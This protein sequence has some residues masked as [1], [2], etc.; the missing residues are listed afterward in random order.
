MSNIYKSLIAAFDHHYTKDELVKGIYSL[1][2]LFFKENEGFHEKYG[3]PDYVDSDP[4]VKG[5]PSKM[6]VLE[7]CATVFVNEPIFKAFS[8]FLPENTRRVLEVLVWEYKMEIPLLEKELKIFIREVRKDNFF[9]RFSNTIFEDFYFFKGALD[10][11]SGEFSIPDKLAQ[12]LRAFYEKPKGYQLEAVTQ[13]APTDMVYESGA[14][15]I[16]EEMMRLTHYYS[17]DKISRN[18]AGNILYSTANKTRKALRLREFFDEDYKEGASV[19]THFLIQL[20]GTQG[21]VSP[22][23]SPTELIKTLFDNYKKGMV[24]NVAQVFVLHLK[25]TGH[26]HTY[27]PSKIAVTFLSLL[28]ELSINEWVSIHNIIKYAKLHRIDLDLTSKYEF[29]QKLYINKADYEWGGNY[30]SYF[31]ESGFSE[32]FLHPTIKATFFFFAA[33]GLLDLAYNQ[34]KGEQYEDYYSVFDG[35][36]YVRLT[37]LGAYVVG[38]TSEYI[39]KKTDSGAKVMLSDTSM[40]IYLTEEDEG[41]AIMLEP[42][43]T[44]VGSRRFLADYK[45]FLNDC[46]TP[47]NVKEKIDIFKKTFG[48]DIPPL[49]DQ[50]FKD[51]EK[52]ADCFNSIEAHQTFHLKED[53]ELLILLS[54]EEKLKKLVIRAED[55][56][57]IVKKKDVIKL[58]N[59]LKEYGYL[60]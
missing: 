47:K 52:K 20:L 25:G 45:V 39:P 5:N 48:P 33:Y 17:Q 50:F 23:A 37:E 57:V 16:L 29:S 7:V 51:L 59:L 36:T 55:Y 21:K 35:L 27:E 28:K 60:L 1:A 14:E 43:A 42:F 53:K 2:R 13:P 30:K 8:G 11:Y 26:L 24:Y 58:R 4:Y 19:R 41:K 3:L 10:E 15:T 54:R 22:T 56:H 46:K 38:K 18:K 9:H 34:P 49:W 32:V 31:E 40:S 12:H 6:M 44:K